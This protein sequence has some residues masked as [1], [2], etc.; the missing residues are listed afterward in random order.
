MY[1]IIYLLLGW[2]LTK[3]INYEA[4]PAPIFMRLLGLLLW[5]VHVVIDLCTNS[6]GIDLGGE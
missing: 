4:M 5:P 1:L 6:S 3:D 2:Y